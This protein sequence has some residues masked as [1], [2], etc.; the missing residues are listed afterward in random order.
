[1][2]DT[3]V[4]QLKGYR[5]EENIVHIDCPMLEASRI[6]NRHSAGESVKL[7]RVCDACG[8]SGIENEA[9]YSCMHCDGIYDECKQCH[10]K[11]QHHHTDAFMLDDMPTIMAF[12]FCCEQ[13]ADNGNVPL[14]VEILFEIIKPFH[15]IWEKGK[16]PPK[17][18]P[19]QPPSSPP[20]SPISQST[21]PRWP[22]PTQTQTPIEVYNKQGS[23]L[24]IFGTTLDGRM[25]WSG[26]RNGYSSEECDCTK[27][28]I[29][30]INLPIDKIPTHLDCIKPFE[31]RDWHVRTGGVARL[32]KSCFGIVI[33][34]LPEYYITKRDAGC[35]NSLA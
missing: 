7:I 19:V 22:P 4:K 5:I 14:P 12:I 28:Y 34:K 21:L 24:I 13:L 8:R 10:K 26:C 9:V 3:L 2:V 33:L 11:S 23:S 31:W 6:V 18:I 30:N 29:C 15:K 17:I 25:G 32:Y 35:L 1:M 16:P 27:V 20:P